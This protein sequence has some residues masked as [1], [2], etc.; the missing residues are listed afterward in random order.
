MSPPV[1]PSRPL[2]VPGCAL[3]ESPGGVPVWE[4]ADWRVIRA[5][6]ADHPA[7]YRVVLRRHEAEFSALGDAERGRCMALVVAVERVLIERL[8]PTKLNLAALGNVVP[9]LHWHVI[10]RF[11][12]DSHFPQPVWGARQRAVE[13]PPAE[14]LPLPLTELDEAV[15]TAL[16]KTR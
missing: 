9:H 7:F 16:E 8:R 11:D 13:P 12:W 14:R 2:S 4:D 10:A 15:R 6:E 5:D 3:C 1:V